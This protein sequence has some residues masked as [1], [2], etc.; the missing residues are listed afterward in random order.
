[1]KITILTLFPGMVQGPFAESM[2]K[3]A[4]DK[5]LLDMEAVYI[6]DF[7][8]GRHLVTDD[9]PFGGGAGLVMKPEPIY[10]AL[11]DVLAKSA[12]KRTA[13]AR[14]PRIILMDPQ[15]E[16]F[17]QEKAWELSREDEIVF[18]CGHYEG[19][20]ERV[21][22]ACTDEISIGDFVLTGGELA[23][24]VVSDAV[25]RL[26]PGVLAEESPLNESFADGVLEGPQYTR[27]REFRGMTVPDILVSGDHAKVARW[28]RREGL[29]RTLQ[30]RPELLEHA[31]LSADDRKLL[32]EIRAEESL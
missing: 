31:E 1:M 4:R 22:H 7:A 32:K 21:R 8:E 18:I 27:P 3:R 17:C 10:R 26:I 13:E 9:Y 29:R 25:A 23:A 11:D 16:L 30:R 19:I 6:R 12:A 5:G 28:R 14:P 20:D 24:L 2:L 15:G